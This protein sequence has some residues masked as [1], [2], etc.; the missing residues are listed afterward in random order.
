M[1]VLVTRRN[2][3]SIRNKKAVIPRGKVMVAR[4]NKYMKPARRSRD[5]NARYGLTVASD[6]SSLTTSRWIDPAGDGLVGIAPG[7][8]A[9][10]SKRTKTSRYYLC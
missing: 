4:M 2:F 9:Q 8:E 7:K 3:V 1:V 6:P 5:V 10:H